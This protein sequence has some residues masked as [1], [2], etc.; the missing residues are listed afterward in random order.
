MGDLKKQKTKRSIFEYIKNIKR[1]GIDEW[2]ESMKRHK[3]KL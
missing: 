3:R 2:N 1:F